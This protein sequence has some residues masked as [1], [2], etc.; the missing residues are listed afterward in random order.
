MDRPD[1]FA[2]MASE[3]REDAGHAS[4]TVQTVGRVHRLA[5]HGDVVPRAQPAPMANPAGMAHVPDADAQAL[6]FSAPDADTR[7]LRFT[8]SNS[9]VPVILNHGD[10]LN[11]W[12]YIGRAMGQRAYFACMA[13]GAVA[14]VAYGYVRTGRAVCRACQHRRPPA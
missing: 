5:D 11:G 3:M 1:P 6:L 14:L 2:R 4:R 7:P 9:G 13:C 8:P 10:V 12:R